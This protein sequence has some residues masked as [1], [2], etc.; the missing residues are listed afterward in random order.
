M[1]EENLPDLL[2]PRCWYIDCCANS[3]WCCCPLD[4]IPKRLKLNPS[5]SF[6]VHTNAWMPSCRCKLWTPF[7][8]ELITWAKKHSLIEAS[9][10]YHH[11]RR[12]CAWDGLLAA[13]VSCSPRHHS[14]TPAQGQNWSWARLVKQIQRFQPLFFVGGPMWP[15]SAAYL[16]FRPALAQIIP[17]AGFHLLAG[18]LCQNCI[19]VPLLGGTQNA[20]LEVVKH[21]WRIQPQFLQIKNR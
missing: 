7:A 12:T 17:R 11:P 2:D 9:I 8:R 13:G 14:A 4:L 20:E 18:L 6:S 10:S 19:I 3:S 1:C 16:C 5:G 15:S 21:I